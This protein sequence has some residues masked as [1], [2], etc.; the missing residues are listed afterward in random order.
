MVRFITKAPRVPAYDPQKFRAAVPDELYR[1]NARTRWL[2]TSMLADIA[3]HQAVTREV[4]Q[5]SSQDA[6]AEL[7]PTRAMIEAG[8][9]YAVEF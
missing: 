8:I 9:V 5:A 7:H 3:A 1:S 4:G 6:G 2:F